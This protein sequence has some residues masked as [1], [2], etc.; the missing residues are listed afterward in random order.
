MSAGTRG[1][2]V[3]AKL[4]R[5]TPGPWPPETLATWARSIDSLT[6]DVAARRA[7]HQLAGT[8]TGQN[9]PPWGEYLALY[10]AVTPREVH[11]ATSEANEDRVGFAEYMARLVERS[12]RGGAE[13]IEALETIA[14]W[15]LV[16]AGRR[17]A[18]ADG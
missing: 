3:A 13:A 1:E 9:R 17:N 6:D 10:N 15:D 16:F 2:Q 4:S 12:G 5:L 7:A 18:A 14:V 11:Q 8:W